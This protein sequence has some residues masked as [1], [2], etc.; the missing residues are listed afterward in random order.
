MAKRRVQRQIAGAV[1]L[2]VGAALAVWGYRDSQS[3]GH[4][5]ADALGAGLSE[6]VLLMYLAGAACAA[7]GVFLIVR[8]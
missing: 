7:V 3:V 6:E 4:Q 8:R 5:V 1:L 2:A